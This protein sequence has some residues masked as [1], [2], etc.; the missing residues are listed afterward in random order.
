[1]EGNARGGAVGRAGGAGAMSACA[2]STSTLDDDMLT[3]LETI[4]S[5]MM[6][7][8]KSPVTV[9]MSSTDRVSPAASGAAR[10]H[11]GSLSTAAELVD[12]Q[13]QP[14]PAPLT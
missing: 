10:T 12:E 4:A 13:V 7:V 14:V 6:L 8:L 11:V 2:V 1:M 5:L 9:T 3:A